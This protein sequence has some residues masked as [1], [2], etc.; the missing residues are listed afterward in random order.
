VILRAF[1]YNVTGLDWDES[2]YIVMAQRWLYGDL[3]YVSIWD[4]HPA[5]LP[6]LFTLAQ[7]LISDGLLA[8]R[9]AALLAVAGTAALLF[10]IVDRFAG[11][12]RTAVLA[13][14]LYLLAM[15]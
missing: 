3:P 10:A 2:L 11:Q 6:A 9:L 12:R 14:I 4:Q 8:A 13:A 15:T 1:S 5:G 7:W